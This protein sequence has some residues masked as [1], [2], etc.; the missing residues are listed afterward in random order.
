MLFST[1]KKTNEGFPCGAVDENSPDS[2]E[3]M[4]SIAGPGGFHALWSI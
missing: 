2:V 4:G 1:K 3:D